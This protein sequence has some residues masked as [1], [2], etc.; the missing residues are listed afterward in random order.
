MYKFFLW[1]ILQFS[2]IYT[3]I[4]LFF[5]YYLLKMIFIKYSILYIYYLLKLKWKFLI[6]K[7][8]KKYVNFILKYSKNEINKIMRLQ[9]FY[10]K[11]DNYKAVLSYF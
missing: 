4:C 6:G 11:N 8:S 7:Y 10:S 3:L 5:N 9:F 2:T 1:L